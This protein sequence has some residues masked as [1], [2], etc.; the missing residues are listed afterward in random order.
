MTLTHDACL[1]RDRRADFPEGTIRQDGRV[2]R[3][4]RGVGRLVA[5]VAEPR[6][7]LVVPYYHTGA[8]QVQPTSAESTRFFSWPK[9]GT[10]IHVIFGPPLDLAPLLA[11]RDRPP[12]DRRPELL[13]EKIAHALEEEV[14]RLQRELAVRLSGGPS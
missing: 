12:F 1:T 8:E 6:A 7:L 5:A 14:R 13:Y 10:P 2:H 3:F 4:R 9:L 11:L